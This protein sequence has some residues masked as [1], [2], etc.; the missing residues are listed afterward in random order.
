MKSRLLCF[1]LVTLGA[2]SANLLVAAQAAP[3][4]AFSA[5][6][7]APDFSSGLIQLGVSRDEVVSLIGAAAHQHSRDVWIYWDF[8]STK[9]PANRRGYDTLLVTFV[10]DRVVNLKLVPSLH[11]KLFL[12]QQRQR[13]PKSHIAAT[14]RSS[15][16]ET[17]LP[18][19]EPAN[20]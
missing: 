9:E 2:L 19:V 11:V 20:Q 8:T 3:V 10:G 12:V 16:S 14:A 5:R 6:N 17:A 13:L 1:A 18:D 15:V 7:E 4:G